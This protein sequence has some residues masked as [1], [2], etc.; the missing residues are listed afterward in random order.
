M[1]EGELTLTTGGIRRM[2]R[3]KRNPSFRP[4]VRSMGFAALYPS[5]GAVVRRY[6]TSFGSA[7]ASA[8]TAS[9]TFSGNRGVGSHS[10]WQS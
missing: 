3:A 2:G 9:R 6:A 7:A 10:A 5:Y 8:S 4:R 1:V